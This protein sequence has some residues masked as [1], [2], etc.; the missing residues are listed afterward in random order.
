MVRNLVLIIFA[1]C[2]AIPASAADESYVFTHFLSPFCPGRTL[3]DCPS[4]KATELKAE[5]RN[6]LNSGQT[7]EQ[8]LNDLLKEYGE[9][10]RAA[11]T[12][13]G[14]GSLAWFVPLGFFLLGLGVVTRRI[15]KGSKAA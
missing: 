8:V 2:L 9:Q 10:Y 6:R 14:F 12:I 5:I 7:D 11:P 13:E 1:L 3:Q 15:F 4:K